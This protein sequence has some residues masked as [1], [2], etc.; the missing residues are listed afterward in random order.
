MSSQA[1]RIYGVLGYPVRHSLSPK[2]QNAAFSHLKINA[3]Y[4]LFEI[5]P[6][7]LKGFIK[8]LN[9]NGIYGL[10]VT[11][12]YK[13]KV[14]DLVQLDSE[15][16]YLREIGAINTVV[17][18]GD[19]LKGFNTDISGFQRH[20]KE[21]NVNPSAKKIA[22]L[23][24]GGAA[25]AVVYALA[26]L[27]VAEISIFDIDMDRAKNLVSLLHKLFAGLN[28]HY[29]DNIE[30][31]EIKNKDM[32][33]NC[34][35]VGMKEEDPLLVKEDSLHK[36]LFVYDLVYNPAE[37]RLLKTA[38]RI[39]AKTLNG[40]GMLLYQGA[41]SFSYFTGKDAPIEVMRKAIFT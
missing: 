10:N 15:L 23:G 18:E 26:N 1:K 30:G 41:Q 22:V 37:T 5:R 36:D 6:Q 40:L 38:K 11:I 29:V 24:A 9:V 28:I 14:L 12:P 32:L 27:Q 7:D 34:T 19:M 21:E 20:L 4:R 13:Q 33:V 39:G 35:P 8:D 2:M 31:L 17:R 16:L 25:R 3:E